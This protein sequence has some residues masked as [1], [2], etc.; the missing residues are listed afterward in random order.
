M[1]KWVVFGVLF[2]ALTGCP[3]CS[4]PKPSVSRDDLFQGIINRIPSYYSFFTVEQQISF[5]SHIQSQYPELIAVRPLTPA[6]PKAPGVY[7]AQIGHGKRHV[8][9]YTLARPYEVMGSMT[10]VYLIRELA[11]NEHLRQQLDYTWHIILCLDPLN[12]ERNEGWFNEPLT[13]THFFEHYYE[14]PTSENPLWGFPFDDQKLQGN[15]PAGTVALMQLLKEYPFDVVIGLRQLIFG[16]CHYTFSK[17]I[18]ELYPTLER[19]I[20]FSGL[21]VDQD[22]TDLCPLPVKY[23]A[24]I[25]APAYRQDCRGM[26][27]PIGTSLAEY[28]SHFYPRTLT[29][30]CCAPF[31]LDPRTSDYAK[32]DSETKQLTQEAGVEWKNTDAFVREDY[33]RIAPLLTQTSIFRSAIEEGLSGF[34]PCSADPWYSRTTMS[35]LTALNVE[36]Q[37]NFELRSLLLLSEYVRMLEQEKKAWAEA[38]KEFSPQLEQSLTQSRELFTRASDHAEQSIL[39]AVMSTQ[40]IAR[41][42]LL[43]I[44]YLLDWTQ[45]ND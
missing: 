9:L 45:R 25:Y 36:D 38:H 42:Q 21:P 22:P 19:I 10:L 32:S 20:T 41:L 39:Y 30:S 43:S 7:E 18:P 13:L 8:L 31:F 16:E 27:R 44:L 3:S 40:R 34:L 26:Q 28:T 35:N 5:L 1:M 17:D 23:E 11:S 15:P 37:I 14:P 29:A 24:G 4:K 12:A 2:V 6:T 33:G